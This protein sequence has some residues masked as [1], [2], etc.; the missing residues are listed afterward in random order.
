MH[1]GLECLGMAG[2]AASHT[3]CRDLEGAP[4]LQQ[5]HGSVVAAGSTDLL[6]A[7]LLSVSWLCSYQQ[8]E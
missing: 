1:S 6:R 4:G 3:S 5:R 7:A 2:P 8:S